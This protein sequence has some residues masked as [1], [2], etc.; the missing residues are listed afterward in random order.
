VSPTLATALGKRFFERLERRLRKPVSY[1]GVVEWRY[2]G[3]GL[4]P[5]AAHWH[6]L[7]SSDAAPEYMAGT[8]QVTWQELFGNALIKPYD[9]RD[10]EHDAVYYV[11]KL[12]A[13]QNCNLT[14]RNLDLLEY[15][16]LSDLLQEAANNPYVPDRL[17]SRVFGEYLVMR[18]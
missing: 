11:A 1:A 16:G 7:A 3:C 6:F 13:H 14:V 12:A 10:P 2:S 5:I 8:A 18:D 15:C 4:S 9:P 17:K